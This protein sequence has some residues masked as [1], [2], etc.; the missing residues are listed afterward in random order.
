MD[1]PVTKP[2]ITH[3]FHRDRYNLA[4]QIGWKE[5]KYTEHAQLDNMET[6]NIFG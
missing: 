5:F 2:G 1:I 6:D 4:N 3:T